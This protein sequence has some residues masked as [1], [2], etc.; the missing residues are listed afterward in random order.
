MGRVAALSPT[1]FDIA[2]FFEPCEK[3]MKDPQFL[4]PSSPPVPKLSQ[5]TVIKARIV[6]F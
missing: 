6:K 4:V 2:S 5:H 1:G 3:Q